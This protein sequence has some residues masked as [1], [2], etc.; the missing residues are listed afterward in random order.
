MMTTRIAT[1]RKM[2]ATSS[3]RYCH[4]IATAFFNR[5][6][7]VSSLYKKPSP[8]LSRTSP[9]P[10]STFHR[11]ATSSATIQNN[12]YQQQKSNSDYD[13]IM[14]TNNFS[15]IPSVMEHLQNED[16]TTDNNTQDDLDW[17]NEKGCV[18]SCTADPSTMSYVSY[19]TL[20]ENCEK[21]YKEDYDEDNLHMSPTGATKLDD[22]DFEDLEQCGH[23]MRY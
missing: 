10:M 16:E 4:V 7:L 18:V 5:S 21:D 22:E 20:E 2:V 14:H 13:S 12:R 3:Y 1:L 6:S 23:D 9:P 11:A 17:K 15:S 19:S 8:L